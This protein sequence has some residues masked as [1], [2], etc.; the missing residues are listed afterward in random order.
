MLE[1]FKADLR[2]MNS[3]QIMRKYI[4]GGPCHILDDNQYYRL[5]E[6]VC[7]HL[8]IEFTDVM[9][10]GSG[11]LGF[12]IKPKKRYVGFG[13]DSDL[14]LAVV[15]E[16]LFENIWEASYLFRNSRADWPKAADFFR[17][18]SL[19]WIRPD[20]LPNSRYFEFTDR[21]WDFFNGITASKAYGPYK[22]RGGVYHS[23]F[24]LQEYQRICIEQ[25]IEEQ[26]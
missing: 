24:F 22:I 8:S 19:G 18:L 26:S 25:C 3:T 21:W 1:A 23:M 14:D 2:N 10:V 11:K 7:D 6:Q 15:S 17:Y 13:E 12:S 16:S 5:R 20:K 9:M 4:L